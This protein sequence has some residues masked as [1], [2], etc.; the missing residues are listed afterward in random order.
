MLRRRDLI[1]AR[2]HGVDVY[3]PPEEEPDSVPVPV[4]LPPIITPMIDSLRQDSIVVP[5]DTVLPVDT[6][7]KDTVPDGTT[8]Q[9]AQERLQRQSTR[10]SGM[11]SA[12]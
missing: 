5:V 12:R 4:F 10:R 1:L 8:D 7:P 3:I 6:V 11:T 2:Y 9:N